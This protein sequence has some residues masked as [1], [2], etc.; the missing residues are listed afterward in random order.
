MNMQS[1][2]FFIGLYTPTQNTMEGVLFM[3]TYAFKNAN[4]SGI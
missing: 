4:I 2:S 1:E 3:P